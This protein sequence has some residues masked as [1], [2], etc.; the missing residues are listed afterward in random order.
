MSTIVLSRSRLA[1]TVRACV[2]GGVIA[3][4]PARC[5]DG[6]ALHP[7]DSTPHQ[8][9]ATEGGID[10]LGRDRQ[11]GRSGPGGPVVRTWT[12]RPKVKSQIFAG[13]QARVVLSLIHISEPTRP[14]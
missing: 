9:P 5:D 8:P 7:A 1:S 10:S 13:R 12:A 14:Y 4:P 2:V 11:H 3:P 6:V